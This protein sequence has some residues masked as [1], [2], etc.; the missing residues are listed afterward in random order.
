[1]LNRLVKNEVIDMADRIEFMQRTMEFQGQLLQE[2]RDN[3][4]KMQGEE[5]YSDY[6]E[7]EGESNEEDNV[8]G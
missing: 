2:I 1:M 5:S 3:Q 8:S 4:M 7:G 6:G